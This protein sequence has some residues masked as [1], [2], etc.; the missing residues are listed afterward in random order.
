MIR[1]MITGLTVAALCASPVIASQ[2]TARPSNTVKTDA[3][4]GW[5]LAPLVLFTG[6]MI[7]L[8]TVKKQSNKIEQELEKQSTEN[9]TVAARLHALEKKINAHFISSPSPADSG[10]EKDGVK[11]DR[12]EESKSSSL[13]DGLHHE[14]SIPTD[15]YSPEPSALEEKDNNRRSP[16]SK[17]ESPESGTVTEDDE[18]YG[19][20]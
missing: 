5:D 13:S 9:A 15:M 11:V 4:S 12:F 3:L 1:Y 8:Y 19:N 20:K 18:D 2:D 10:D 14:P 17:K 16:S 7:Y 6:S